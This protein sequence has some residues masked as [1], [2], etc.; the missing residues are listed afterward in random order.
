M[1]LNDESYRL[2]NNDKLNKLYFFDFCFV[3]YFNKDWAINFEIIE[4]YQSAS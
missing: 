1:S 2:K 4:K 3:Y